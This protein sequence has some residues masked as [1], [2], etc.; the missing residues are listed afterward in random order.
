MRA[1][2]LNLY[3]EQGATFSRTV[4]VTDGTLDGYAARGQ[5]RDPVGGGKI[6]D[7]ACSPMVITV[8]PTAPGEP[9]AATTTSFTFGLTSTQT[10]AL[11]T[12][13]GYRFSD[14]MRYTYDLEIFAGSTVIR[15]LN[16]DFIV[17]PEATK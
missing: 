2:K 12:N 5:V 16:G 10:A 15:L 9:P 11:T 6:V 7:L 8:P 14:V 4:S 17:S 3:C 13:A 1:D